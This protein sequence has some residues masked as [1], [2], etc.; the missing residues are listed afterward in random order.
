MIQV[1]YL[2][3][4]INNLQEMYTMVQTFCMASG[5][6]INWNKSVNFL[7]SSNSTTSQW[8]PHPDFWWILEG[9]SVRYLECQV[10]L[11][12]SSEVHVVSLLLKIR[13]KLLFWSKAKL[14]FVGRVIVINQ[15]LLYSL[16]YIIS[17]WSFSRSC[18]EQLQRLVW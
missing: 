5:A 15:V 9:T 3:G 16:W 2:D 6:S 11:N 13:K 8:S 10:G 1:L 4:Q 18:M 7:V 17:C 12:I 14:S